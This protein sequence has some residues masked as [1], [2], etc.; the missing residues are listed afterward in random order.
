MFP[1]RNIIS[2]GY[3]TVGERVRLLFTSFVKQHVE[4][5]VCFAQRVNKNRTSELTVKKK[6]IYY[7]H[8]EIYKENN[9][10]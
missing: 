3:F 8:I 6:R 7:I 9:E 5:R 2:I 1:F 10:G 4:R